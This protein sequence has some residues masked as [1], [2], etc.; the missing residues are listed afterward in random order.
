MNR[1]KM[2]VKA[3]EKAVVTFQKSFGSYPS[4]LQELAD[5]QQDGAPLIDKGML[6]DSWGQPYGYS[7][8]LVHPVTNIP[9]II[10][11]GP[12]GKT[13]RILNWDMNQ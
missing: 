7:P 12:P 3:L 6:K 5:A 10:S 11:A 2:D 8:S 13:T 1:A 4:S 9:L